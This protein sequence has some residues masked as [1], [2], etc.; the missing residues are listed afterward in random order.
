MNYSTSDITVHLFFMANIC[1]AC[2]IVTTICISSPDS[3]YKTN[4]WKV[5]RVVCTKGFS[6][7]ALGMSLQDAM[8][9]ICTNTKKHIKGERFTAK[10]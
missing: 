9:F 5:T 1:L 6:Q 4:T 10:T 2:Y 3:M 7:C 8:Y